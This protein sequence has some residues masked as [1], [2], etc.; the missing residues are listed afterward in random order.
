MHGEREGM[1]VGATYRTGPDLTSAAAAAA[2]PVCLLWV[3]VGITGHVRR[4]TT[5][6]A[7]QLL[8]R[9]HEE[10]VVARIN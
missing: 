6:T 5:R 7:P 1:G 2:A 8:L 9:T 4:S 10:G 3:Q